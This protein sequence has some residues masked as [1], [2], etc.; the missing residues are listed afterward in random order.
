MLRIENIKKILRIKIDL[1]RTKIFRYLIKTPA[2]GQ[3]SLKS[4]NYVTSFRSDIRDG[5]DSVPVDLRSTGI[6]YSE[7]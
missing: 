6:V 7:I 3:I 4:D 5:V 2:I 1:L